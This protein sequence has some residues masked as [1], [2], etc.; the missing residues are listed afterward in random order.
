M[1][2]LFDEFGFD[3]GRAGGLRQPRSYPALNI[4]DDGDALC[5]EAEIPGVRKEDLEISAMG[6]ELI[7][8][9]RRTLPEGGKRTYHRQERLSGEFVRAITL[10]VDVDADRIEAS[11]NSGVLSLRLPKAETAKPRKI[12][13]RA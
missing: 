13:V 11:L 12:T 4:W 9:G 6:N 3:F 10:P 1:D 8:K 7:I 2:R 5:A